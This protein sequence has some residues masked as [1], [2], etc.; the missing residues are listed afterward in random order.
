MDGRMCGYPSHTNHH[1]Q[2][3]L[4]MADTQNATQVPEAVSTSKIKDAV[5]N[6]GDKVITKVANTK[7]KATEFSISVGNV[8]TGVY[9]IALLLT[10]LAL[11]D[12][13]DLGVVVSLPTFIIM[14]LG[15]LYTWL[16]STCE[17]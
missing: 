10:S 8:C 7:D 9:V 6:A 14:T 3:E 4:I 17:K 15:I 13:I 5:S 11:F 1:Y 12:V 2:E 16:T